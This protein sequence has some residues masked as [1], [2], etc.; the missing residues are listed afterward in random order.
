MKPM[1]K[2]RLPALIIL[3][4]ALISCEKDDGG[5]TQVKGI[6]SLIYQ[7]IKAYREDNGHT[8]PFVHQ[9]I[10]VR[11]A[12]VYSYKMAN[13]VESLGTGGLTG[14]W[15]TIHEKIGG[16]NDQSIVLSSTSGNE[17]E[18]FTQILQL[19]GAE[20]KFLDDLT[21]CGVGVEADTAGTNF[22]TIL[23]MKVD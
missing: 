19:P 4:T 9:F 6:E 3:I 23:L 20:E 16:Y 1:K 8:G 22:I 17:D 14:H 21:Q 18:I 2:L 7:M 15:S 5:F 12:Q 10:M 13:G 11:E